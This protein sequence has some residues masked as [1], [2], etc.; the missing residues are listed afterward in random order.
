VQSTVERV[1]VAPMDRSGLPALRYV[2]SGSDDRY[3]AGS[4]LCA[5]RSGRLTSSNGTSRMAY[6]KDP[7]DTAT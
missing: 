3:R 7:V 4:A 5:Q 2:G 1:S 6:C